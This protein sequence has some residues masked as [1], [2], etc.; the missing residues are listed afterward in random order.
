VLAALVRG[1]PLPVLLKA[2]AGGGGRGMAVIDTLD[3][4]EGRASTSAMREALKK[5]SATAN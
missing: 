5:P 3:G 4:L 2:V 1:M